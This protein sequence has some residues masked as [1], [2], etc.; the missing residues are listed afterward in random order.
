MNLME[1][2]IDLKGYVHMK[3]PYDVIEN[4]GLNVNFTTHIN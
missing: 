2:M 4:E 1:T 3:Q